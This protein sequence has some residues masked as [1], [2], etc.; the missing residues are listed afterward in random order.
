MPNIQEYD[1]PLGKNLQPNESAALTAVHAASERNRLF[2]EEGSVLGRG[3]SSF[4]RPLQEMANRA[5]D[6][7][8]MQMISHGSA[9][10]SA[11]WASL[12]QD[13]NN[14]MKGADPNDTSVGQGLREKV[15][16]PS[17]ENFLKQYENAPKRAQEWALATTD[18]MR[19][20]FYKT[21]TADEMTR[22]GVA[23][24]QNR[25]DEHRNLSIVVGNDPNALRG[26]VDQFKL[27][28]E[29]TINTSGMS[30]GTASKM[31]L[32][33]KDQVASL[34]KASF[35]GMVESN[36]AAAIA[37]VAKGE[38]NDYWDKPQQMQ[39]LKYAETIGKAK[40]ADERR[41]KVEADQER[42]QTSADQADKIMQSMYDVNS[43]RILPVSPKLNQQIMQ[44]PQLLPKEKTAL[45]RWNQQQYHAQVREDKA[46]AAGAA[47]KDD[48]AVLADAQKRVGDLDNP[49][50]RNEIGDLLG[51]EKITTKT[52]HD[53]AWRVGQSDAAWN[54]V[55]RPFKQHFD[56][57]KNMA[58]NSIQS[59]VK[60]LPPSEQL[61]RINAV[62]GDAQR[63]LRSAYARKEDM[64]PYLDPNSPQYVL[65]PATTGSLF[66]D[67]KASVAKEADATRV[68]SGKIGGAPFSAPKTFKDEAAVKAAN[69]PNG[70]R[71]IVNGKTAIWN[72]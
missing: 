71:V 19:D 20:H 23:A 69:L 34:A 46:A 35:E 13:M 57:V 28:T 66:G 30:L 43:G 44:D 25:Q 42:R 37:A 27:N 55:Q 7:Q 11:L 15:I 24:V 61:E 58:L 56:Q 3:V 39:A 9:T 18:R 68:A 50:T 29:H 31:R 49:L 63:I 1:N 10:S 36:P 47:V 4:G 22:A 32:D 41:V 67:P 62:E 70:T 8:A 21:I 52:A 38:F 26:A 40:I 59:S 45:I 5:E 51:A 64:R 14:T 65:G 17:L 2:R 12:T 54:A 48:A 6:A 33:M 53:L 72:N 60:F 16:D